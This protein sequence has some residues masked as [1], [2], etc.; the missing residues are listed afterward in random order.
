MKHPG[1]ARVEEEETRTDE[2]SAGG[3]AV[4][5]ARADRAV[6]LLFCTSCS[7]V[8]ATGNKRLSGLQGFVFVAGSTC[9][10]A[11]DIYL[12]V[13]PIRGFMV[14]TDSSLDHEASLS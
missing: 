8:E 12:L 14:C 1:W 10:D 11:S 13:N 7:A 3:R 4:E 6:I 9:A 2:M 5:D